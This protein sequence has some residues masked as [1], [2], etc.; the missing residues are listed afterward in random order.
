MNAKLLLTTHSPIIGEGAQ[1]LRVEL[2]YQGHRRQVHQVTGPECT[3]GVKVD[4][5]SGRKDNVA[6]ATAVI[7][8]YGI[9]IVA[10]FT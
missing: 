7:I 8:I 3:I 1:I 2:A 5:A 4:T 10:F 6:S 9:T